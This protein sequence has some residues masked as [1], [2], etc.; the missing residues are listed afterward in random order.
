M[1][2]HLIYCIYWKMTPY[3]KNVLNAAHRVGSSQGDEC[4]Q[5][6][7]GSERII[8]RYGRTGSSEVRSGGKTATEKGGQ[9]GSSVFR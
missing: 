4:G 8:K 7:E 9:L 6:W 1:Q 5:G 3:N 2:V